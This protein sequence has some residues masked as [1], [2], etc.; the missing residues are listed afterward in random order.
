MTTTTTT[1]T[2]EIERLSV[3]SPDGIELVVW[4]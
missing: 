3:R 1:T 2:T 4:V